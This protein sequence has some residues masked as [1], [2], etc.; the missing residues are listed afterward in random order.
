M[1]NE[2]YFEL[3][4]KMIEIFMWDAEENILD[5]SYSK[6]N[7]E[8]TIQIVLIE[9]TDISKE[10]RQKISDKLS[11]YK[12]ILEKIPISIKRYNETQGDWLP[13]YYTWKECLLLYKAETYER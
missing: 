5:V 9:G 2:E 8:V 10:I 13:K 1:Y 7:E 11:D 4:Y 12:V 3:K 6:H